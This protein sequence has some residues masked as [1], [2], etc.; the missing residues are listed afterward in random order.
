MSYIDSATI[1]GW[2]ARYGRP[3]EWHHH[4]PVSSHD[5]DGIKASQKNGRDHDITFYIENR[6]RVA[7]IAKPIYPRGLFRAPSGGLHVGE[8]LEEGATREAYEETGL[9]MTLDRYLLRA[10]VVF[11]DCGRE[12]LWWTHVFSA[13]TDDEVIA[14]VDTQEIREARWALPEEFAGF[15]AQMAT[16]DRGGL[17]YR[18]ALHRQ[19]AMIHPL[20][21]S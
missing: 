9:V 6:G 18:A 3:V 17:R 16:A 20:F 5:F 2:E 10:R 14:P 15:T 7:V 12:I 13:R 4:Q 21:N 8:T 1:A 11:E 19:I